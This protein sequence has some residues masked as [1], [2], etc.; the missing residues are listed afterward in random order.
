[1]TVDL[2]NRAV[3]AVAPADDGPGYFVVADGRLWRTAV[4]GP[5]AEALCALPNIAE[6]GGLGRWEGRPL[7][8]RLYVHGP[9]VCVT[10]R[11]GLNATLVN[12]ATGAVRELRRERYHADV[13]SYS[14]VFVEREGRTLLI[15][16]TQWN[17]LD[18]FDAE[19]GELLT[20]REIVVRR[21]GERDEQG[22]EIVERE[23]Y[24]PLFHSLLQVSPD[25]R[26]FLGHSWLW[27]PLDRIG[28]YSVDDFL[29]SWEAGSMLVGDRTGNWDRPATFID[30]STFVVAMDDWGLGD[31]LWD[32][33]DPAELGYEY[34]QLHVFTIP[35]PLTP[36]GEARFLDPTVT[37]DCDVFPLGKEGEV[38][39][40]LHYDQHTGL[41]VAVNANGAFLVRLDGT[42]VEHLPDLTPATR[43]LFDYTDRGGKVVGWEY[44][45]D[46]RLFYRWR[47]GV[48]IEERSFS[49]AGASAGA[50]TG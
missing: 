26:H 5:E 30:D 32:D 29:E 11:L 8:L 27:M 38:T 2:R 39:G 9:W 13:S 46:R 7:E 44:S 37:V 1:M 20:D 12:T 45:T 41:L 16:Q 28:V 34:K 14:I 40:E 4:R 48:G 31:L 3:R 18:I 25:F 36:D 24:S 49:W 6:V 35:S 15:A 43:Y 17:R 10:E 42:V 47:D 33:E 19:T 21:T 23:N 50:R 22:F